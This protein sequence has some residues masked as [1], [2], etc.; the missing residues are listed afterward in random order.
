MAP[1]NRDDP[2][3]VCA[4]DPPPNENVYQQIAVILQDPMRFFLQD[5]Q[6]PSEVFTGVRRVH[7]VNRLRVEQRVASTILSLHLT[8]V[9]E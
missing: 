8:V 9:S 7:D 4:F 1:W 3:H 2:F 6:W 5:V